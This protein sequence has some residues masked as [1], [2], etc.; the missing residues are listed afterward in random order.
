MSIDSERMQRARSLAR[1]L[2]PADITVVCAWCDRVLTPGGKMISHGICPS[3]AAAY[4]AQLR[5]GA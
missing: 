3:C 5:P 4:L 1:Q 2:T